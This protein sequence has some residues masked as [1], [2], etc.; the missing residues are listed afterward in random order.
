[1]KKLRKEKKK[2]IM[3]KIIFLNW[4]KGKNWKRK[5]KK[6]EKNWNKLKSKNKIFKWIDK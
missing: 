6:E 2:E 1:M 4:K 5:E 3:C